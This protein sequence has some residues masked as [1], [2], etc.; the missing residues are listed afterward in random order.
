MEAISLEIS[1]GNPPVGRLACQPSRW[2]GAGWDEQ[3]I[4]ESANRRL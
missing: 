1:L 2:S 3:M 4:L